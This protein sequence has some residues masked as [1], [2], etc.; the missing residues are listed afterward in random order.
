MSEMGGGCSRASDGLFQCP[1]STGKQPLRPLWLPPPQVHQVRKAYPYVSRRWLRAHS[2]S[3]AKSRRSRDWP[4]YPRQKQQPQPLW[5]F[6]DS[7][8][9][10]GGSPRLVAREVRGGGQRRQLRRRIL[11][12]NAPR[13]AIQRS[14]ASPSVSLCSRRVSLAGLAE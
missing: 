10:T 6:H 1:R 2:W 3:N 12:L 14:L 8:A 7:T 4:L 11:L 13:R 5:F 9:H